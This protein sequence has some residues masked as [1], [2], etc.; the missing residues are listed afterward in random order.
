MN[1]S[2][3]DVPIFPALNA[4][5]N[6]TAGLLLLAGYVFARRHAVAAH[7]RCMVGALGVSAAFLASYLWYHAHYGSRP[8]AGTGWIRPVYFTILISHTVLAA[9]VVPLVFV[10]V[11]RA[12]RGDVERHRRIAKVTWPI[13]MY[14]SVTGVVVYFLL[15]RIFP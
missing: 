1:V 12:L 6:A 15:Y 4:V 2:A 9:A 5:L 8:F 13:W 11:R 3:P 7:R 10:T 14:V